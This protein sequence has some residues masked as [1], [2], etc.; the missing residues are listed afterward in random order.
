MPQTN[1]KII[2]HR[3]ITLTNDV[4]EV[5]RLNV[6]VDEVCEDMVVEDCTLNSA[7]QCI[8]LSCPSDGTIRNG[9]FRNLKM[10]GNNGVLSG[11]GLRKLDRRHGGYSV[12][13]QILS[14]VAS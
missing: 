1:S 8:R 11:R 5:P 12:D 9:T 2:S 10:S 3:S 6:F 13:E 7:C 14:N 4:Q